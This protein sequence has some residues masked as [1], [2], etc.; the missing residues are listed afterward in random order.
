MTVRDGKRTMI[1]LHRLLMGEPKG[2]HVDHINGNKLDNR[3]VNLRVA[4]YTQNQANRHRLNRNNSSGHR[5]IVW[6]AA[7]GKWRAQIMANRKAYHLG[8][9]VDLE[10]AIQARREAELRLWGE[11]CPVS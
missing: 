3:R 6:M 8:L 9:F 5:G 7:W 2:H 10:S 4:T 1:L 11:T